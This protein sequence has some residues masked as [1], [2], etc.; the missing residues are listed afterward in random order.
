MKART[1]AIIPA[2]A[3]SKRLPQKNILPFNGKPLIQ[4]T[5]ESAINAKFGKIIVSSDDDEV[6][7]MKA[8]YP[9]VDFIKRPKELASDTA[10]TNDVISHVLS[11]LDL[12]QFDN[13][14]LL[15]PTSPLRSQQDIDA[16]FLLLKEGGYN[17]VTSL[18]EVEHPTAYTTSLTANKSLDDFYQKLKLLPT[19]SQDFNKE[20]RLNGA[21]YIVNISDFIKYKTLFCPPGAAYIMSKLNSIDID[22]QYD[23]ILAE[24]ISKNIDH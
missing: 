8:D 23:F 4:W 20:Y 9:F 1:V 24:S 5:I 12:N 18:T 3:G 19:R 17:S 7:K 21:I 16:A 13:L 22:D 14:I 6:L 10:T 11:L 15:Q 2:R